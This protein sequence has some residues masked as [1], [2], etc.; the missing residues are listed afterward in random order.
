M[1]RMAHCCMGRIYVCAMSSIENEDRASAKVE[2]PTVMALGTNA[3]EYLQASLLSF[4][5]ATTTVTAA[6]TAAST[7][8]FIPN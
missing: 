2:E 8:S 4:P 7:A 6:F 1:L 5:A 3:G